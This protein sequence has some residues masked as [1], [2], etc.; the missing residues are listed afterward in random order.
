MVLVFTVLVVS[1]A[2]NEASFYFFVSTGI[3]N[4]QAKYIDHSLSSLI[5]SR[6]DYLFIL[7]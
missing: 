1:K 7:L 2:D 3:V 6:T 5:C 4:F